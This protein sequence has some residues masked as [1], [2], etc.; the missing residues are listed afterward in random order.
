MQWCL[1]YG[2]CLLL[3][4]GIQVFQVEKR[5]KGEKK[6]GNLLDLPAAKSEVFLWSASSSEQRKKRR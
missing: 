2:L 6:K 1:A 3:Q 4:Q 5:E